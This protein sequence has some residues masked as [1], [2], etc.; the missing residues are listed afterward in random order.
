MKVFLTEILAMDPKT[1]KFRTWAGF[2]IPA[3]SLEDAQRYCD[4]NGLGFCRVIGEK[5][6]NIETDI[7]PL[8][9]S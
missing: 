6:E 9:E 4:E 1:G 5:I 8:K 2:D 7:K 3:H